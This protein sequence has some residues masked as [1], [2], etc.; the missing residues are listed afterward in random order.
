MPR[1]EIEPTT[2]MFERKKT[3]HA[4]DRTDTVIGAHCINED[5]L[6]L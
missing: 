6:C 4:L 1:V 3:A 2:A 5:I